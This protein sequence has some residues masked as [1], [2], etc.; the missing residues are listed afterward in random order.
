MQRTPLSYE[1]S[2]A[3]PPLSRGPATSFGGFWHPSALSRYRAGCD[4][5]RMPSFRHG[6]IEIHYIERGE[7]FPV[8]LFAPGGMRSAS[9]FWKNSPWNPVAE[10]SD[11]FRV[12]SMDQ[13]NAGKSTARFLRSASLKHSLIHPHQQ[14][15]TPTRGSLSRSTE[16]SPMVLSCYRAGCDDR[17]MPSFSHGDIEIHYIERGEGFPVLLFAPGGIG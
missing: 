4:D 13:R 12:I 9:G 10:L 5:R 3:T 8:L 16:R 7:G 15:F 11:R 17:R 6:D 14:G 1:S 2:T